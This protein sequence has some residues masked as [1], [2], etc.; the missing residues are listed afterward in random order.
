[1][2]LRWNFLQ[3]S[4]KPYVLSC[5][6]HVHLLSIFGP[7]HC[8]MF[9]KCCT[10]VWINFS[11]CQMFTKCV[12]LLITLKLVLGCSASLPPVY[13]CTE[14][15]CSICTQADLLITII[16]ALSD[17]HILTTFDCEV[18]VVRHNFQ[19]DILF[20]H[21]TDFLRIWERNDFCIRSDAVRN[22]NSQR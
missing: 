2:Y 14:W 9:W 16:Y 10:L 4:L 15:K 7:L 12:F 17:P 18:V 1:M 6:F 19:L 3:F 11:F 21:L 13:S 5:I 8:W 20:E 22:K